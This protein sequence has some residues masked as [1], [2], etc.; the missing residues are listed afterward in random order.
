MKDQRKIIGTLFGILAFIA[1]MSG[2]T[3]ALYTFAEI[4]D[5]TATGETCF[6]IS[7]NKGDDVNVSELDFVDNYTE[8][9]IKT[10]VTFHQKNCTAKN[11]G[12]IHINTSSV[13]SSL[14][15]GISGHGVLKYTIEKRVGT[16]TNVSQT[17]T[18]YI[19]GVGTTNVDIGLL[20]N[21]TATY[22]VYLWL[23]KDP[24]NT[25]TN[26]TISEATY[27]GTISAEAKQT[28]T[29]TE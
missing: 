1:I 9:A 18:G 21:Q 27:A 7:Y 4:T 28:S 29:F 24:T 10:I 14:V 17:Y 5:E 12:T 8:S 11:N 19:T 13:S 22:T 25:I 3:Y 23:E 2:L 15:S 20:E 6:D 16:S 26:E